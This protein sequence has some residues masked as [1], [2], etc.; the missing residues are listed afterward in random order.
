MMQRSSVKPVRVLA[1]FVAIVWF[2]PAVSAKVIPVEPGEGRLAAALREAHD[3]DV[4]H[5]HSGQYRGSIIVDKSVSI[6]GIGTNVEIIGEDTGS[7]VRVSAP[8]VTIENVTISGSGLLLETRDSGIFLDKK[9]TGAQILNNHLNN[10]LIGVYV[11]GARNSL[12]K[13][14]RII[15]RQD[16]RMNERGNG[17]QIWNAP[18]ARIEN[19]FIQFGRDG[20]F[21]NTSKQN[22]FI[23]NVMHDLRFAVHYMYA[24]QGTLRDNRSRNNHLGYAVMYS[25]GIN[26]DNNVSENDRDRGLLFNYANNVTATNNR[27]SGGPRKCLFIYNSNKNIFTHNS[28]SGCKVGIH[29]T[30]GSERNRL[31]ENNFIDNRTQVKYV[32]TRWVDWSYQGHGNY[33]STHTAFDLNADGIADRA[34]RPNGLSDQLLW[35]YPEARLLINSPAMQMLKWAQ[36]AFPALY[37]GGV[38]DPAPLMTPASFEPGAP[39]P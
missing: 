37:P 22:D 14:N 17:V 9:A 5:L 4:L 32:G 3:G 7:T 25:T 34:Y 23:G 26:M 27:V 13:G 18:G 8:D 1:L 21:V 20:I 33:W 31:Y 28:F 15:G 36:S 30:G 29:F 11:W 39:T 12:V 19:N 6:M 2:S 10:N 24:D 35:R 38:I 16:L